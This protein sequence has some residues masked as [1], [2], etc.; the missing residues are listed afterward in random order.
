MYNTLQFISHS[1]NSF[2]SM[3]VVMQIHILSSH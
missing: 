1:A 3:E 2:P